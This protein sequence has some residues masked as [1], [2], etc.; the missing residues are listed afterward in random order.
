M[1]GGRALSSNWIEIC[2]HTSREAVEAVSNKMIEIGLNGVEIEDSEVLTRNWTTT[3]GEIISLSAEEYPT[4]GAIV[5]GYASQAADT[6][7]LVQ[8]IDQLVNQLETYGLDPGP[9]QVSTR[10]VPEESWAHAWKKFYK[11]VQVTK[12]LTVKPRWETYQP[13]SDDEIVIELDPGMA[14]GTGTHPTTIQC[15]RLMEKWISP[16]DQV[17]DVGC[18]SGILS[19][20]AAEMGAGSVLAVDLDEVAVQSA[21]ENIGLSTCAE[22]IEVRQGDLLQD[23]DGPAELIVANL[24]AEI[25]LHFTGDL[26]RVLEAKGIF[27]GAG[28]VADKEK[29]VVDRLSQVGL[30][31]METLRDGDWVALAAK[32]MIKC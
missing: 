5:K 14:F 29:L 8:E 7:H 12:R 28:I 3:Y 10:M 20:A 13:K 31:I 1:K 32:K 17:I 27:I 21:K 11:P 6:D 23:I 4:E 30:E 16:G 18:G 25:I 2:V 19:I 9:R 22:R 15:L 24:L 26:P